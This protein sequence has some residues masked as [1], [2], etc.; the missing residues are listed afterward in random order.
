MKKIILLSILT[1]F[2]F[3]CSSD[4]IT[5]I[6]EYNQ[7]YDIK[8]IPGDN[9]ITLNFWSGVLATDFAGFNFYVNN[10]GVFVQTNDAILNSSGILPTYPQSNH[11]RTN[12]NINIPGTYANG[13][14]YYASVTA[15]GTNDLVETK[16]IETK[17]S[18]SYKVVPRP[19][20]TL[21]PVAFGGTVN[22]L[23][24]GNI[25]TITTNTITPINGYRIQFFGVQNDFN[26]VVTVTNTNLATDFDLS[27]DLLSGGLYIL[28][29]G[30]SLIKLWT[31]SLTAG[32]ATFRWAYQANAS[33]WF[34]I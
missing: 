4:L 19:E 1:L 13:T 25:A 16:Y 28:Y 21:I 31:T 8:V 6:D 18:G 12:F 2:I 9:S 22:V 24:A 33:L 15:Y 27:E 23:G 17:I 32:D 3:S 11:V 5:I 29:N 10:T 34:G 26:A 14:V 7:P 30:T 20:G